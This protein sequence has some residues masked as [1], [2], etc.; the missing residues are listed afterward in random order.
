MKT[1]RGIIGHVLINDALGQF[2]TI[3]KKFKDGIHHCNAEIDGHQKDI[4]FKQQRIRE[5]NMQVEKANRVVAKL[6]AFV[7]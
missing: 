7:E 6:E 4:S 1:I 2:E 5:I 3:A